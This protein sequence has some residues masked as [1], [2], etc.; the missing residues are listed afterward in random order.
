MLLF[1][2]C[3]RR[4]YLA[5]SPLLSTAVL[6]TKRQ[7][8]QCLTD[9]A[10]A[11]TAAVRICHTGLLRGGDGTGGRPAQ[12][13]DF[14]FEA[15]GVPRNPVGDRARPSGTDPTVMGFVIR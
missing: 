8:N 2:R 5:V 15:V 11:K 9:F 10:R 14:G 3:F 1:R 4:C 13:T 6:R 12:F 7:P